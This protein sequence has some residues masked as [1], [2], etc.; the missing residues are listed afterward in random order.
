[1]TLGRAETPGSLVK[2]QR[3]LA[4]WPPWQTPQH[5]GSIARWSLVARCPPRGVWE[6]IDC[7]ASG[8]LLASFALAHQLG[9]QLLRRHTRNDESAALIELAGLLDQYVDHISAVVTETY[10]VASPSRG[11]REDWKG[12]RSLALC[13]QRQAIPES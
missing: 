13:V 11:R 10:L 5:L 12:L 4:A 8:D 7:V 6:I 3:L 1:M 9:W 2:Q